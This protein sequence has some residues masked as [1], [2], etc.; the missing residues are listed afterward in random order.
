MRI[1]F[2]GT[3]DFASVS[4]KKLIEEGF[5]IAAVFSQPD[6]PSNR[7]MKTVFSP[8]KE[9]ALSHNIPV[10][11]P[12]KLRDGTALK[13]LKELS[14]DLIA[15]VAYGKILPQEILDLPKY[16][17]I[18]VHG[19]LL[20]K[21]RG[22]APIQWAVLNGDNITGVTTMYLAP[23]MD[24]GDMIYFDKTGIGE[25]E[26]SGELFDRLSEMGANLLVKTVRSIAAGNAPRVHQDESQATY[27][28]MLKKDMCP[29]DWNLS[30]RAIVKHIY[31]LQPW[32]VA[33]TEFQGKSF[34]IFAAEYTNTKTDK[35]PGKIVSAGKNGIEVACAGGETL[36][37]TVLQAAGGKKMAAGD[38]LLGHSLTVED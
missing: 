18:N 38:Y 9:L 7:G 21:Y 13:I 23:E 28:P 24:T 30:P 16:G 32:P 25:F 6:R 1:V 11:Q 20:P 34:R 26:T 36:L 29:I 12:E 14:P 5:D 33:T 2:M 37:I 19:S 15:V 3:P 35:A 31:G 8:V 27:A 10:Y 17:C 22:S 4:L